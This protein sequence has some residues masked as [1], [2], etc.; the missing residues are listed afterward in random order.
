MKLQSS[1]Y[2]MVEGI[3]NVSEVAQEIPHTPRC[4]CSQELA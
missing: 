2:A 1:G 4:G 3:A